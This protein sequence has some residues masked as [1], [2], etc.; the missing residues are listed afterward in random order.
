ME[1][2]IL[3]TIAY[4]DIFD[5]PL[6]A[7]EIHKWIIEQPLALREVEK[8][9]QRLIK[10]GQVEHQKEYYVLKGRKRLIAK[11]LKCLNNSHFLIRKA[12]MVSRLFSFIPWVKLVG[13]SGG[14]AMENAD[15][16]ADIDLFVITAK[17]RLWI[18]RFIMTAILAS[19]RLKR[20]RVDKKSA[21]A[22]KFCLNLILEEDKLEQ[23]RKNIFIAHEILQMKVLWSRHGIYTK[24][25]EDNNWVFSFLPNWI[26][27]SDQKSKIQKYHSRKYT[28]YLLDVIESLCKGMQ[29]WYMQKPQ[30]DERVNDGAVYFHPKD[31]GVQITSEFTK[32]IKGY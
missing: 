4:A 29:L 18:S 21:A 27:S 10:K 3:K 16:Y 2:V 22:G 25:L 1:K 15:T 6:K 23:E 28:N 5:Y 24:Y 30:G 32:R 31:Y 19:L 14:L 26:E 12:F 20:S 17:N 13:I 7:W 8:T 11:R 9:L